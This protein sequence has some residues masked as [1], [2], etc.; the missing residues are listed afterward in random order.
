[1]EVINTMLR[2]T[3]KRGYIWGSKVGSNVVVGLCILHLL[4]AD[5]RIVFYDANYEQILYIWM[6]LTYFEA[7][8]GLKVN[9]S[10]SE[11]VP[12]GIRWGS[13]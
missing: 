6:V 2:R 12:S 1:M 7:V 3:K 10:K 13:E 11:M 8:T 4:F 9:Q 5:D